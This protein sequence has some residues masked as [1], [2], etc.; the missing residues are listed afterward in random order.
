ML[1]DNNTPLMDKRTVSGLHN[2]K[3]DFIS[4]ITYS[5]VQIHNFEEY[6]LGVSNFVGILSTSVSS[7]ISLIETN[8]NHLSISGLATE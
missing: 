6:L 4:G 7:S 8:I 1:S 5:G 3:A 2:I